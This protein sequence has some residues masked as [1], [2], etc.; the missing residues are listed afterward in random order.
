[1]ETTKAWT[2]LRVGDDPGSDSWN[3]RNELLNI[4]NAVR[5]SVLSAEYFWVVK[6]SQH[7]Q[8]SCYHAMRGNKIFDLLTDCEYSALSM[9]KNTPA[10][11][12]E[13]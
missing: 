3:E 5:I 10:A 6:I 1:M 9:Y 7:C 2:Y 11:E 13:K 8:K 4:H 12:L